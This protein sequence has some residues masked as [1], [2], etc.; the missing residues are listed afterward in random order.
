M[1]FLRIFERFWVLFGSKRVFLTGNEILETMLML[2]LI[3][4]KTTFIQLLTEWHSLRSIHPYLETHES[5]A[6]L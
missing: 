1:C 6:G 3:D 2:R 5:T 4:V